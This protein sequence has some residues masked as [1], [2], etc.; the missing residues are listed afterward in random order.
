MK[1]V[2]DKVFVPHQTRQG[3]KWNETYVERE[4]TEITDDDKYV[5]DNTWV[6]GDE[7]VCYDE[8]EVEWVKRGVFP[9]RAYNHL[10][11]EDKDYIAN[12]VK[13]IISRQIEQYQ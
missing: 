1:Q 2:G 12:A 5:L 4:I 9:Q 10:T 8:N 7:F 6:W 3:D 11:Q 13:F